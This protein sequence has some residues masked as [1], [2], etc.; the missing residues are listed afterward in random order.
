MQPDHDALNSIGGNVFAWLKENEWKILE[1]HID[2]EE[3]QCE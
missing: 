3:D 2:E 1:E